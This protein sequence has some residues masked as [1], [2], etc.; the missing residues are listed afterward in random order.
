MDQLD[1]DLYATRPPHIDGADPGSTWYAMR[2]ADAE[3]VQR[4]G[5]AMLWAG[6]FDI[7]PTDPEPV[8]VA[9]S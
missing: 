9:A 2:A 7:Y 4:E 5:Q 8:E 6:E 1:R 3:Q